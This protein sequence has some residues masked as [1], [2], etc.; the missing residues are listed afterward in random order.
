MGGEFHF[1]PEDSAAVEPSAGRTGT[2]SDRTVGS[3]CGRDAISF[4]ETAAAAAPP[5]AEA[6]AAASA[7]EEDA[8]AGVIE[9]RLSEVEGWGAGPSRRSVGMLVSEPSASIPSSGLNA[10]G[11]E[12]EGVHDPAGEVRGDGCGDA[13]FALACRKGKKINKERGRERER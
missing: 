6:A 2:E 13:R 9:L 3:G 11:K 5:A 1:P 4:V 12:G 7:S 10:A 8:D